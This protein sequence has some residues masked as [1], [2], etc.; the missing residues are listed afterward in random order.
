M[1]AH[2]VRTLATAAL[3][4]GFLAAHRSVSYAQGLDAEQNS[5]AKRREHIENGLIISGSNAPV[6]RDTLTN[7]MAFYN[8]PGVSI[9]VINNEK[10]EWAHGYGLMEAAKAKMVTEGT[11]FQA[12]SISKFV[13]AVGLLNLVEIGKIK[14]DADVNTQLI[15][16]H[17]PENEFTVQQKVTLNRL[18]C[19]EAGIN[20][21][22]FAGYEIGRPIPTLIEV[23]T[24]SS[25]ANSPA[26]KVDMV[27]G[28]QFRYS[29]GGYCIAQQLALDVT[30]ES[31]PEFMQETVLNKVDMEHS[32]FE[33][34]LHSAWE[35]MAAS[36]HNTAGQVIPGKWHVYPEMAA[37]GLWTTPTDLARLAIEIEKSAY[38]RS[39]KILSQ[40]AVQWMLTP[41]KGGYGLG[42]EIAPHRFSHSG[43]NAGF[44]CSLVCLDSGKGAVVMTN[45]DTGAKL[46]QE[47]MRSIAQEYR[48]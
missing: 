33:E 13:S 8:V 26:I 5:I 11:V 6:V 22:G 23:L 39:N 4:F 3:V 10:V 37:A 27:P 25:K 42:V 44:R 38:G 24:G 48:W 2:V 35:P 18:L 21:H 9:A 7:R 19:H 36:G 14:L 31:F 17:V 1:N 16:W 28:S 45:S 40:K 47:I 15:S 30:N 29:G 46:I 12:A 34:P 20:I 43:V 41:Q 32:S